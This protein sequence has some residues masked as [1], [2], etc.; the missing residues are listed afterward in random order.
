MKKIIIIVLV[1][2]LF[3]GL[4]G[5]KNQKMEQTDA[6]KFAEEYTSINGVE[7]QNGKTIRS[8]E[9]PKDN[10]FVYA[11]AEEIADKI[12]KKE[13]FV[14]YFGFP[15]CPWCRS[16]LEQLVKVAKDKKVEKIYYVNVLDIRDI[17][18]VGDDGSINTTREGSEGY[19]RLLEQL[20]NVLDDYILSKDGE[21]VSSGEKRIFAPNIVA[22]SK[23]K[24]LQLETGISEELTDPYGELTDSIKEYAYNK[25][26]CLIECLEEDSNTCQKNMC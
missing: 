17:K 2:T 14:V 23:G 7:N 20:E 16:V 11:S 6:Y 22:I 15:T 9:I 12:D 26:K 24:A 5:C 4:T 19:N 18:E 10:P 25:F 13:S 3:F 1:A 21:P 8:I